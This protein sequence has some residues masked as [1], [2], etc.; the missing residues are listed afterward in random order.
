MDA[1]ELYARIQEDGVKFISLQFTDVTGAVKS[2]DMPAERMEAIL[3]AG[4][5][6]MEAYFEKASALSAAASTSSGELPSDESIE[7]SRGI[8]ANAP[9]LAVDAFD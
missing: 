5:A 6:A 1:K 8:Q 2:V 4:E 7:I 9:R 3:H